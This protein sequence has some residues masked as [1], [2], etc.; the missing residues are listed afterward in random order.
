MFR[1]FHWQVGLVVGKKPDP[2]TTH[3]MA[4]LAL[5]VAGE[6]WTR[7]DGSP[8]RLHLLNAS[9]FRLFYCWLA[10]GMP[11]SSVH[12][13]CFRF[14]RCDTTAVQCGLETVLVPFVLSTRTPGT[15]MELSVEDQ[16]GNSRVIHTN[17]MSTLTELCILQ[18]CLYSTNIAYFEDSGVGYMF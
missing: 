9:Y 18:K 2:W 15:M 17:Y 5:K 16:L 8:F 13:E 6:W 14:R 1:E 10:R 11:I 12:R 4:D 7:L 3:P